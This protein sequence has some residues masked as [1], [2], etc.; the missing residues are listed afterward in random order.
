MNP[1]GKGRSSVLSR[2][3]LCK[4]LE[5]RRK[6]WSGQNRESGTWPWQAWG[7]LL[8]LIQ[9]RTTRGHLAS[10]SDTLLAAGAVLGPTNIAC[11]FC[12]LRIYTAFHQVKFLRPPVSPPLWT[13]F[14]VVASIP[15]SPNCFNQAYAKRQLFQNPQDDRHL[16]CH[17]IAHVS[18]GPS[19]YLTAQDK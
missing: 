12:R 9:V 11:H 14:W 16:L 6:A 17:V 10:L 4:D 18:T 19:D 1:K 15:P 13:L 7:F 3:G 8:I 2:K 5:T